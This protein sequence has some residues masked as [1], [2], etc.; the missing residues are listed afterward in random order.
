MDTNASGP[1]KA[2]ISTSGNSSSGTWVGSGIAACTIV[3]DCFHINAPLIIP[4][5]RAMVTNQLRMLNLLFLKKD[6]TL[7]II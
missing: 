4:A 7:D 6:V 3:V 5:T 1:P 2:G